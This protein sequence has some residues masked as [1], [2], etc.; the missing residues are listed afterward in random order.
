MAADGLV[1]QGD[2]ASEGMIFTQINQG[3]FVLTTKSVN[4]K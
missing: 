2:R 4:A 1:K 3:I